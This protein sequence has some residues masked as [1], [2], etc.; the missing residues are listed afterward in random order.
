MA[1]ERHGRGMGTACHVWIGLKIHEPKLHSPVDSNVP[2]KGLTPKFDE[3]RTGTAIPKH[4]Q[5]PKQVHREAA[6]LDTK[7]Y[8]HNA[9]SLSVVRVA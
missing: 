1:G 6:V 5:F 9:K 4:E 3:D 8:Y 7:L 2:V